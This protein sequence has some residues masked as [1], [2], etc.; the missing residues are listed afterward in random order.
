[1]NSLWNEVIIFKPVQRFKRLIKKMKNIVA[2]L[3]AL[4]VSSPDPAGA[5]ANPGWVCTHGHWP[6]NRCR[7]RSILSVDN[8]NYYYEITGIIILK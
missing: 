2:P 5:V 6:Q 7:F 1:M 8:N 3:H 4:R